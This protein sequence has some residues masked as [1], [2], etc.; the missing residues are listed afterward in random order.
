LPRARLG[1]VSARLEPSAGAAWPWWKRLLILCSAIFV[2]LPAAALLLLRLGGLTPLVNLFLARSLAPL[3]PVQVRVGSLRSDAM[4]FMEADD[5]VVLAPVKGAKVPLMT[6]SSLR[7]EFDAYDTLRG[8]LPRDEALQLARIRG[9]NV[10]VLR[11]PQGQWNTSVLLEPHGHRAASK[12]QRASLPL[13]PA[14]RVELEDS[15]VVFNNEQKGF[16]STIA[17]LEGSLD[18]RALPLLAFSLAGRTEGVERDNLSVAGEADLRDHSMDSRLDLDGVELKQYLNYFLPGQGLRFEAGQASLSVRLRSVPGKEL[19]AE[20]SADL[21]GGQLRIPGVEEPL[22]NL[23]GRIAFD[24]QTLRF[25]ALSARFLGS[26]WTATGGLNDLRQ[27][28]FDVRLTNAA[29]GLDALSQQVKGLQPLAL[30]GSAQVDVG[31][32]GPAKRPRILGSIVAPALRLAGID[33]TGVHAGVQMEGSQLRVTDLQARAWGGSLKGGLSLELK[34][35]GRIQADAALSGVQLELA[36]IN[37]R[38]PLPLSGTASVDLHV[39]GPV[40][41]AALTCALDVKKAYLGVLPLGKVSAQ[42]HW[43]PQDWSLQFGL[44]DGRIDGHLGAVG[45]PSVFKDSVIQF[46]GIDQGA[47]ARGFATAPS[48]ITLPPAASA[49]AAW[50]EARLQGQVDASV[51]LEGPV[52]QA[53]AWIDFQRLKGQLTFRDGPLAL[54][55]PKQPLDLEL[56]GS[57]GIG[58][59][60]LAMG[61]KGQALRL[62]LSQKGRAWEAQALGRYPLRPDGKPGALELV[63]DA[64]LRLLDAFSFFQHSTGKLSFDGRVGGSL[65]APQAKGALRVDHFSTEPRAY[66][67]PVKDGTLRA[68]MHDQSIELTQLSF[69]AGG[70]VQASGN[71]DLSGGLKALA[72]QL[73]VSTDQEGLRFQNW[74][75]MGS[76]NVILDPL[77]LHLTGD[78]Q[79]LQ[80][81]GHIKLANAVVVYGG[82]PAPADPQAPAQHGPPISLDLT[83]ALG[84]NVWY[85]KMHDTQLDLFDPTQWLK[86][87]ADSAIETLQ[88]PDMYFRLRPTE[89]DFVLKGT[90]PDVQLQGDLQI[91]RGKLTVMENEFE[92]K[93]GVGV[94]HIQ[95]AGKRA[96][97]NASAVAR[98]RYMRDDP[99]TKRPVQKA[100]NVTVTIQ[101]LPEEELEKSDLAHAFLN[102]SLTFSSDP[103][104]IQGNDALQTEAIL[105]LVVLGDPMVDLDAS[106]PGGGGGGG[107]SSQLQ[108]TQID[109]IISA[110][111]RKQLASLSKHGLKF[112]GTGWFDVF[113]V[114][115]HFKYQT[116]SSQPA[117]TLSASS[118]ADAGKQA[119]SSS[120][121]V[122]SDL[123]LELGK[124]ITEKLYGSAQWIK[125]SENSESMQVEPV[126]GQ[127]IRDFGG[128]I[129]LEYQ[130]SPNRTLEGYYNY[131]VDE[132]MEPVS[133]D[134]NDL[135][136]AQSGVVELRNTIPTDNYSVSVARERRWNAENPE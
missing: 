70:L 42:L 36:R 51:T 85:Q 115:P 26:D 9:L 120:S 129:G 77:Q 110:E 58:A 112:L 65:D 98:L 109:R 10:F 56:E 132:N 28:S 34:K 92:I 122:F 37:G 97:V 126:A 30:S 90:T 45:K 74:D 83:V 29:F 20:G 128:R 100:V 94:S 95:F 125:F 31:L 119:N 25:K 107:D 53:Q 50:L 86:G 41:G 124:S 113:R 91:D 3:T 24:P 61:R 27:P 8:R 2:V 63:L 66:L 76:G 71:V 136:S 18:T 88:R 35:S 72:G 96:D 23:A 131:S 19:R 134:P 52:K 15:Q 123:T 16:H 21:Q 130:I 5:V 49:A 43:A 69:R 114:A 127:E 135:S 104:I 87:A 32:T 102:Y 11:D 79:P 39:S 54:V 14:G 81:S 47:L 64:D 17:R 55:D 106:T 93:P 75:A 78:G 101:P 67:A 60:D 118:A 46:R 68:L 44:L 4:H 33:L 62:R 59:G 13:L 6:I 111:A 84:S 12:G 103:L 99:L 40:R 57:L 121:L 48:A 116:S 22:S 105:D 80:V 1:A 38:R 82:K 89:E 108:A 7:L 133:F 117:P 73:Q